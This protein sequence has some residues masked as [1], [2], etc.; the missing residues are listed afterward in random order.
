MLKIFSVLIFLC[1]KSK[2]NYKNKYMN[3]FCRVLWKA[4]VDETRIQTFR[5]VLPDFLK[6]I[7]NKISEIY[8]L[9]LEPSD[10][11]KCIPKEWNT[12]SSAIKTLAGDKVSL[13]TFYLYARRNIS[14]ESGAKG[15]NTEQQMHNTSNEEKIFGE[16]FYDEGK[17]VKSTIVNTHALHKQFA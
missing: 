6:F 7:K 13:Q 1:Q 12:N 9:S 15:Y 11:N 8:L 4:W 5:K 2:S 16:T 10:I 3:Y 17:L 14:P